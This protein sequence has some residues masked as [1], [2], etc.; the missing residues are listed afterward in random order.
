MSTERLRA[1][2]DHIAATLDEGTVVGP[3]RARLLGAYSALIDIIQGRE[4]AACGAALKV[5]PKNAGRGLEMSLPA[6]DK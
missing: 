6:G 1:A 3:E 5:V 2:R 4:T